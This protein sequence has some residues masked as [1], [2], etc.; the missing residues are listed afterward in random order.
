MSLLRAD[1]IANRFNTH[2]PIIVGPATV[3]SDLYV[4][5]QLIVSG[6]A[7]TNGVTVG[8]TLTTTDLRV[9]T[10][11]TL[12]KVVIT[13]V[14]TAG[15]ITGA[16]YHGNGV[17]LTGIVTQVTAGAGIQILGSQV[18]GKGTVRITANNVGLATYAVQAG[19][20]THINGGSAGQLVFQANTGITSFTAT[21]TSGE[22]LQSNGTAAPSWTSLAA[23]NVSYADTAGI[24]TNLKGGSSGRIPYQSGIDQ[25]TFTTTG[26]S[27]QILKSQGST[28]PTWLT[29]GT[30]LVSAFAKVA[31]VSTSVVGGA[32]S[33]N[34]LYVTGISTLQQDVNFLQDIGVVGV[35]TTK[36]IVATGIATLNQLEV[37]AAGAGNVGITSIVDEDDMISDSAS[38]L[39]TQQSVKAY[40]DAQ[41]TAQD[42]DGSADV[43]TFTVDLDSQ[44]LD[45]SGTANEIYTIGSGQT[46]TVGLDTNVTIPNNLVVVGMSSVTGL[47]TFTGD[48]LISGF[49]TT[50][51]LMV[52]GAS[53]LSSLKVTG[54]TSTQDLDVIGIA[55]INQG[56]LTN[57]DV[58]G[59]GTI[60]TLHAGV[61]ST[62]SLD[63]SG[64]ST[65]NQGI[66]SN[67]SVTGVG[68][69]QTLHAGVTSTASLDVSGIGTIS[70]GRLTN[71]DV[72]GVG[73]VTTLHAGITSSASLN[74]SGI[75]TFD[76][77]NSRVLNVVGG[78]SSIATLAAGVATAR[79]LDVIGVT[80]L[81]SVEVTGLTT[82]NQVLIAGITTVTNTTDNTL[83]DVN[84]GSVQ[85]DG[86][87][88]IT[89]NLTVGAGLT[90][91]NLN[92]SSAST[93]IGGPVFI[94][95]D[96][97][98]NNDD[99]LLQITGDSYFKGNVG[100]GTTNIVGAA[101][102]Q[103][104]TVLNVGIIT[105]AKL[106]GDGSA[107]TGVIGFP[108]VTNL[109]YV[110]EDG[111]DDDND[112]RTLAT[113]KRTVGAALTLATA[114]S[115]IRVSAGNYSEN[116]PLIM[117]EQ[118]SIMGDSLRE[119][120]LSPQNANEDFIYVAN[121][122]FVGDISFTGTLNEG[123]AVI[124]FN[125]NKPSYVTQ[126]PYIRNAT[127][128]ISN[129][130]GMKIDGR[131]VMGDT[132]AMNVDS[133]TQYNQGGIGVSISNDGYAQ[134]VSIFTIC[135]DQSIVCINGG[136][137][138]L[139][140]SNSSFGRL[141]LVADGIG[142]RQFLGTV[143]AEQSANSNV[144]P[145]DI[146]VDTLTITDAD[147]DNTTGLTTITTSTNH[148]FNVG[149]SVTM[150]DMTF[151][152]DSQLPV[153]SFGISTA[154]Y[155]RVSWY[156]DCSDISR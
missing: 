27:G 116:N 98:T 92:V 39:P 138:D 107:L 73:T 24:A 35:V 20:S 51:T 104:T 149:M 117:P 134:L 79:T 75:G 16:T 99:Q 151:T 32:A 60:T 112:G 113:A 7:V 94:G 65:F 123:R 23:I 78:I 109:L 69:I 53:T 102:T 57:L 145:I 88:G 106:Y 146:G 154:N 46:V 42:L 37:G 148:G 50:G 152:C 137:C 31:G 64:I 19:T 47:A 82:T 122:S 22:I 49:T 56:R 41:V 17:N 72:S 68:T 153:T 80:T 34:G 44:V 55:T 130:V 143:T 70:Q 129:S 141:G 125:P 110:T 2:G 59:V 25:T 48:V 28:G 89:G 150:K 124:S 127:N 36:D 105:A 115:I 85:L 142:S 40:V 118:V 14:T 67:F 5:D 4:T 131:H 21:G 97:S 1:R 11:A 87:A 66:S 93:F 71:L 10:L 90:A 83:G 45:V 139:T 111:D 126:G 132:K 136:Q 108:A 114:S 95:T 147:Y 30:E 96:V 29:P 155:D 15:I 91:T 128:F 81:S 54:F 119:V 133:Y 74:V 62:A 26:S 58:S 9:D 43:G 84:T 156:Y 120:S 140:N 33:V 6:I 61:T 101:D 8:T 12:N 38:A 18:G 135:N 77:V 86:G 100:V 76:T 13:G 144:F 3:T 121:G 63:V 52:G 103:N